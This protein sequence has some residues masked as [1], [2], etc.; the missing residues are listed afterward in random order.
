MM[1]KAT[2]PY[3]MLALLI[4]A[5][6]PKTVFAQDT[7]HARPSSAPVT[8][9][10]SDP[11][12]KSHHKI[13]LSIPADD[14][15]DGIVPPAGSTDAEFLLRVSWPSWIGDPRGLDDDALRILGDVANSRDSN[16]T[17]AR[18]LLV[19]VATTKPWQAPVDRPIP[20]DLAQPKTGPLPIPS[21]HSIM[22]VVHNKADFLSNKDVY[23]VMSKLPEMTLSCDRDGV[24]PQCA[25]RFDLD[26]LVLEVGFPRHSVG[27]WFDIMTDVK[28]KFAVFAKQS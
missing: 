22:Q 18:T 27:S 2:L 13:T 4:L 17:L 1:I 5:G 26:R 15:M 11:Q 24:V 6:A 20:V 9:F 23:V 12:D 28:K 3:A 10:L 7:D 25:E 14:F 21:G 16:D 8:Y 19:N